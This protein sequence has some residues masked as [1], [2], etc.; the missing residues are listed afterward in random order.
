MDAELTFLV[1]LAV[2]RRMDDWVS[3]DA[4]DLA[5]VDIPMTI[6]DVNGK[7]APD[8]QSSSMIPPP[9]ICAVC[10]REGQHTHCTVAQ[11]WYRRLWLCHH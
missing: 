11:N 7:Y 1:V 2:N 3:L 9:V 5:T 8:P 4:L 10:G 6:T